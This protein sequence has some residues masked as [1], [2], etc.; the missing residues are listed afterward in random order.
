MNSVGIEPPLIL[1]TKSKPSP[2]RRLDV[3][4]DDAVLARAAGLAD[5]LALDLRGGAADG[6]AVG[7]LR[8][9]DVGLDVEL[10]PHAVDEDLEVQLAHARRSRSGRSPRWSGP[11]RSG[12]PRPG[13][14]G[15]RDIFSWSD[16]VLGSTATL[17]TGS[18]NSIISSLIGASGAASVSPGDDLLDADRRGDVAR[19]DL[20]E[21]LAV[22]GVHHQDAADALGLAGRDVEDA[23]P[24]RQA[25]RVHAEVGELADERVGHDLERQRGERLVVGGRAH[26][27]LL[28]AVA[29]LE[30]ALDRRH[31]Q[32]RRQV[33][34]DGVE[35]GLHAL[36]LERRAAED[37]G[38]LDVEGGLADR[39]LELRRPRR[40][41]FSR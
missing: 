22:V 16:F 8:L 32:R 37:R 29:V 14:R 24:G 39:L 28:L 3:D 41:P 35:Q 38:H 36:V 17:M 10:A 19:V 21:L 13:G 5:E 23:R 33:V 26:D 7:D 31:V 40:A 11:G 1:E 30:D 9:A 25:A 15:R 34:E 27:G 18:G 2:G 4:V 12:P 6:L 20:V